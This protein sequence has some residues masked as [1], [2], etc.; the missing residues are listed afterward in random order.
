MLVALER[1][2]HP[3]RNV[4]FDLVR[5]RFG[6]ADP[7]EVLWAAYRRRMPYLVTCCPE[8]LRGLRTLRESGWKVGIVTNGMADNQL[9]KIHR[10]GLADAVDAY[11]A[12]G[13]EGVRGAGLRTIWVDHDNLPD[14]GREAD[15][16]VGDM[17]HAFRILP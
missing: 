7:V 1:Q 5:E 16:V 6:L 15:H 17:T 13:A 11:A 14:A 10:T 2:S 12:S 3:H 9:G 4:F 8:V